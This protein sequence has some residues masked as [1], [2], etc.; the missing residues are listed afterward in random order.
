MSKR[1]RRRR[2]MVKARKPTVD[3]DMENY[4]RAPYDPVHGPKIAGRIV[5]LFIRRLWRR[6]RGW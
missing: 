3:A 4:L 1:N 5:G 2:N 6:L